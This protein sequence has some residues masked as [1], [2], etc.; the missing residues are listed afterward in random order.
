M[1]HRDILFTGVCFR[2]EECKPPR[3]T[4]VVV[5]VLAVEFYAVCHDEAIDAAR[6]LLELL[7]R[8]GSRLFIVDIPLEGFAK[9]RRHAAAIE[10][11]ATRFTDN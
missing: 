6:P 3:F 10:I 11:G 4:R 9:I 8:S 2:D 5:D 1:R 7:L